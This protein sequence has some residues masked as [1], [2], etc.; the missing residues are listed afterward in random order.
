VVRF[1][2]PLVS[3]SGETQIIMTVPQD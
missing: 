2:N 1:S 3:T